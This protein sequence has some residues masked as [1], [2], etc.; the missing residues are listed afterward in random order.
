MIVVPKLLEK[1]SFTERFK[2]LRLN[3]YGFYLVT[4]PLGIRCTLIKY[5]IKPLKDPTNF[6]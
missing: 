6:Y 1:Q 3:L 5:H 4:L 2:G